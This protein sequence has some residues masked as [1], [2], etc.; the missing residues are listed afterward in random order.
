MKIYFSKKLLAVVAAMGISVTSMM[1]YAA[2]PQ[3]AKRT[4]T[5]LQGTH[6]YPQGNGAYLCL[7]YDSETNEY[8]VIRV[9]YENGET[10]HNVTHQVNNL[11]QQLLEAL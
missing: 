9:V 2:A 4:C 6:I 7:V 10:D 5:N 8:S 1:T 11:S 3:A